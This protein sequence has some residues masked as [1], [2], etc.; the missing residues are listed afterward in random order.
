MCHRKGVH[1]CG[2]TPFRVGS[3]AALSQQTT[4]KKI[5]KCRST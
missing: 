2:N 3:S 5:K 4:K 1:T